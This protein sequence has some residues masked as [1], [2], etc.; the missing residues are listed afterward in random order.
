MR[1]QVQ[2]FL[3]RSHPSFD[4]MTMFS[5]SRF[6]TMQRFTS[7]SLT[8]F[9]VVGLLAIAGCDSGGENAEPPSVPTGLRGVQNGIA[10]DLNWQSALN[11]DSYNV[12]RVTGDADVDASGGTVNSDPITETGFSDS[13]VQA[14]AVYSYSVTAVG[15]DGQESNASASITLRVFADPPARP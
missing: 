4:R 8:I 5:V 13:S 12:Y 3:S 7:L 9:V 15:A 6:A 1:P 11:A 14:G 2:S 10:V